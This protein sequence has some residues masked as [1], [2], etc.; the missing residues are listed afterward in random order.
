MNYLV[1]VKGYKNFK[2]KV[3]MSILAENPKTQKSCFY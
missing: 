3:T 1:W 2:N